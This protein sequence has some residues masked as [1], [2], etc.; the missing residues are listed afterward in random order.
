MTNKNNLLTS[1]IS[2][3]LAD[4]KIRYLIVGG[5]AFLVEYGIFLTLHYTTG[6]LVLANVVSFTIALLYSFLLH[7]AWT[8]CGNHHYGIRLQLVS[9]V[10]LG[11]FNVILTSSLIVILVDRFSLE[12][13]VAKF[14]CMILVIVWNFIISNKIIF[15]FK[16]SQTLPK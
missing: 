3:F 11:I 4:K 1:I 8:F 7:Y 16:K 15:R 14:M 9:Y 10:G 6:L 13:W 5:S 12:P 2:R